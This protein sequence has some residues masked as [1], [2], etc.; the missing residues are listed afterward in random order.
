MRLQLAAEVIEVLLGQPA[1]EES[2]RV[3]AGRSVP[4]DIN[5]VPVVAAFAPAAEEVVEADFVEGRGGGESGNMSAQPVV[6]LV[7][8]V[9]HR[10]RVPA[11]DALDPPLDFAVAGVARLGAMG[12]RVDV[13]RVERVRQLH[14]LFGGLAFQHGEQILGPL[15]PLSFQDIFERLQP[16]LRLRGVDVVDLNNI[17]LRRG[18]FGLSQRFRIRHRPAFF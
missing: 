1:F 12:N 7:G 17:G 10:H 4:L 16:F 8:P 11:D 5:L 6:L 15:G 14:P 3:N 18:C 2:P 13:R 9:H